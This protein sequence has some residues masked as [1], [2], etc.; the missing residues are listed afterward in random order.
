MLQKSQTTFNFANVNQSLYELYLSHLGRS[1]SSKVK[2]ELHRLGHRVDGPLATSSHASV[3]PEVSKR[4]ML[5]KK[6]KSSL[7]LPLLVPFRPGYDAADNQVTE[8][9]DYCDDVAQFRVAGSL[10]LYRFHY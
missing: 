3:D 4:M 9:A 5:I 2:A 10:E 6:S 7:I 1:A 8:Q